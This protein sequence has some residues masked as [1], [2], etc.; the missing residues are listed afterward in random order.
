MINAYGQVTGVV[1]AVDP[2]IRTV[3]YALA[4]VEVAP[5]LEEARD[6]LPTQTGACPPR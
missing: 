2:V 1:F 6:R 5:A 3:A 4:P